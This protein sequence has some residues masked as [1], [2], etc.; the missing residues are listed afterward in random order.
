MIIKKGSLEKYL[1]DNKMTA[2]DFSDD[3]GIS[4][5]CVQKLLNGET[6]CEKTAH[7][8]VHYLGAYEAQRFVDWQVLGK[9]NPFADNE[10]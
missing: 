5:C 10:G 7:K 4:A 3:T 9:E 8:F 2:A 6:V 1:A